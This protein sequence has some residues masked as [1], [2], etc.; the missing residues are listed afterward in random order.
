MLFRILLMVA[1]LGIC[2]QYS[3]ESSSSFSF[4]LLAY[5]SGTNNALASADALTTPSS[6]K[7]LRWGLALG[8]EFGLMELSKV[9]AAIHLPLANAACYL[10]ASM[11]GKDLQRQWTT[12]SGISIRT[13]KSTSIGVGIG[14]G[15]SAFNAQRAVK[16]LLLKIGLVQQLN[17]K[18]TA[19]AMCFFSA[20]L[21]RRWN[22]AK[23]IDRIWCIGVGHEI[24]EGLFIGVQWRQF[25]YSSS[26]VSGMAKWEFANS[27]SALGG[28]NSNGQM[29]LGIQLAGKKISSVISI[30][31]HSRL[32]PSAE[33]QFFQY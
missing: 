27:L 9:R 32:G 8:N 30:S 1:P 5:S 16:A 4:Q 18:T 11:G 31:S 26:L 6:S 7:K 10:Q 13:S 20:P 21:T 19:G 33:F 29:W 14:I 25:H 17:K 28:Y 3:F 15:S 22:E 12:L 24:R 2:A 23:W